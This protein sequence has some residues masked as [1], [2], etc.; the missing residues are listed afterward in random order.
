MKILFLLLFSCL[1]TGFFATAPDGYIADRQARAQQEEKA[2]EAAKIAEKAYLDKKILTR[3]SLMDFTAA[4]D[5]FFNLLE[6]L[7]RAASEGGENSKAISPEQSKELDTLLATSAAAEDKNYCS[8]YFNH[9]KNVLNKR[10]CS[11][12]SEDEFKKLTD[13]LQAIALACKERCDFEDAL[14]LVLAEHERASGNLSRLMECEIVFTSFAIEREKKFLWKIKFFDTFVTP[15]IPAIPT[16]IG[17]VLYLIRK[18]RQKKREPNKKKSETEL[19]TS[20]KKLI[21]QKK[22]KQQPAKSA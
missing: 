20:P 17:L 3:K 12:L 5:K 9:A 15:M 22:P 2:K 4:Q 16:I 18:M 13:A 1:N 14:D 11:P 6:E 7:G 21:D 10:G 19:E 8:D